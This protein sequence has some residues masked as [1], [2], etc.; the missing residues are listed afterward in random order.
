MFA[1]KCNTKAGFID[2]GLAQYL[3]ETYLDSYPASEFMNDFD[4]V[5]NSTGGGTLGRVGIYR[6]SYNPRKLP[7][8][9]DSHVTVIRSMDS[10]IQQYLYHVLKF[11]QPE[12]E[13]MGAGS[14][15]QT[16]LRPDTVKALCI[17]LPPLAEQKRIAEKLDK[18]LPLCDAMKADI[19]G[20]GHV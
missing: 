16:E 7:I 4:I 10:T 12:L 1:Q 19:S 15:N 13:M 8:V 20:G 2:T 5:I 9:P 11:I 17:P 3:D 14:T 18:L 6:D